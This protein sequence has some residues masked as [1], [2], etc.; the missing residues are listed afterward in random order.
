MGAVERVPVRTHGVRLALFSGV[1]VLNTT[2][3]FLVF[4]ALLAAGLPAVAANGLGFLAANA[5]SYLVNARVTFRSGGNAAPLSWR[6]FLK[7]AGAHL[8]SL[9]LSSAA[10]ILLS[11]AIGALAAKFAAAALSVLLNY[12][13]S[14]AFAFAPPRRRE[15]PHP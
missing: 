5:Q 8:F 9:F 2:T 6:G 14:A 1:G 12:A 10:I 15:S 4:V 3:D 11:D 7:F 13:T